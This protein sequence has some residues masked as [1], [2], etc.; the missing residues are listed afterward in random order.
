MFLTKIAPDGLSDSRSR[1]IHSKRI[2][3][4]EN[5]FR[6]GE[7][8]TAWLITQ[9]AT[10]LDHRAKIG[11]DGWTSLAV[12][13]DVIGTGV[14]LSRDYDHTATALISCVV[15][16]WLPSE[17]EDGKAA[18]FQTLVRAEHRVSE[19]VLLRSGTAQQRVH[20]FLALLGNIPLELP[21][22]QDTADITGLTK[23]TVSRTLSAMA[24]TGLIGLTGKQRAQFVVSI[25]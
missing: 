15:R 10:R 17:L 16:P 21:T 1:A 19:A 20:R 22:L 3:R 7:S 12:A 14:L 11:C 5:V 8:G 25:A 4:G 9:G 13:G 18:L 2:A 24:Q 23:E 6:E